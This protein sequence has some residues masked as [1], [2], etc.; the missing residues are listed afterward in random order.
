MKKEEASKCTNKRRLAMKI[1]AKIFLCLGMLALFVGVMVLYLLLNISYIKDTSSEIADRQVPLLTLAGE[2]GY[3]IARQRFAEIQHV[4]TLDATEMAQAEKKL[5]KWQE[6]A[7][8]AAE[9][10]D[11]LIYKAETRECFTRL[12]RAWRDYRQVSERLLAL[13]RQ[14]RNEEARALF[15][16]ESSNAFETLSASIGELITQL[17]VNNRAITQRGDGLYVHSKNVG[18]AIVFIVT[19]I[20]F[21]L[22]F[23]LFTLYRLRKSELLVSIAEIDEVSGLYN[24]QAFLR[25]VREIIAGNLSNNYV[26]LY[27]DIDRFRIYNDTCG[28]E[29]GNA[30]L[31]KIGDYIKRHPD[32][33][34]EDIHARFDADHFVACFSAENFDEKDLLASISQMFRDISPD[35]LCIPRLGAYQ[36]DDVSLDVGLMCDRALLAL[37]ST[38]G[39]MTRRF[40]WYD[41]A[42][43]KTTLEE[44]R[45]LSEIIAA[46][47]N[48]EFGIYLQ[49]QYDQQTRE[50]T[51]GEALARWFHPT[52][53]VVPPGVFIDTLEKNGQISDLSRQIWE[54]AA[55]LLSRRKASGKKLV[56]I[57]VN[58]SRRDLYHLNLVDELCELS[59][60]HDIEPE[61]LHLEITET[62]Y[63]ENPAQLVAV[64][65]QLRDKGFYV[66]MDDFGSGYSSLNTLKTVPVDVLK[67]DLKFL[68][69]PVDGSGNGGIILSSVIRMAHWLNLRVIA[70][71]V[72]TEQQAE[73]LQTVGCRYAQGYFYARPM[74]VSEFESLLDGGEACSHA[75]TS[76]AETYFNGSAF[77]DPE[78]QASA[79]FN[80]LVGASAILEYSSGKLSCVRANDKYIQAVGVERGMLSAFK[81]GMLEEIVEE[82]RQRV[83]DACEAAAHSMDEV[84]FEARWRSRKKP[85]EIYWL[86]IRMRRIAQSVGSTVFYSSVENITVRKNME[87]R[88]RDLLQE[89]QQ[90]NEFNRQ[91]MLRTN[92]YMFNMDLLNDILTYQYVSGEGELK[93]EIIVDYMKNYTTKLT[94]H[95]DSIGVV[96]KLFHSQSDLPQSG[97]FECRTKWLDE[98]EYTWKRVYFKAVTDDRGKTINIIGSFE[99]IENEKVKKQQIEEL[100]KQ[101]GSLTAYNSDVVGRVFQY[102]YQNTNSDT[103][104]QNV[105][106]SIGEYLGVSRVYIFENSKDNQTCSNTYEWCA[107]GI[108]PQI[109]AL[110]NFPYASVGGWEAYFRRFDRHGTF[111]VESVSALDKDLRTALEVQG[112]RSMLQCA[113]REG[114]DVIGYLGIDECSAERDWSGDV[115]GTLSMASGIIGVFLAKKKAHDK[116]V[117]AADFMDA[118]ENSGSYIYITDPVTYKILYSNKKIQEYLNHAH[119]GEPC[120]K[121]FLNYDQ[122]CAVC[123]MRIFEQSGA[124]HPVEI[125]RPNGMWVLCQASPIFWEGRKRM[126]LTCTDITTLKLAVER[127]RID[128]DALRLSMEQ[129]GKIVCLYDVAARTL[130]MPKS[131][132]A[133]RGLPESL[134]DMPHA[135]IKHWGMDRDSRN[136]R[137]YIAFYDAIHRG[138]KKGRMEIAFPTPGGGEQYFQAEFAT[139]FDDAG[140]PKQAVLALEDVT[141]LHEERNA[142]L[143]VQRQLMAAVQSAYPL[144]LAVNLTENAYS[145]INIGD[146]YPV[147]NF[148][149]EGA[150]DALANLCLNVLAPE[151][152]GAFMDMFSLENMRSAHQ[153]GKGDFRAEFRQRSDSGIWRWIE[154]LVRFVEDDAAVLC[155]LLARSIDEQ[156]ALE[157]QLQLEI[158]QASGEL[159]KERFNLRILDDHLLVQIVIFRQDNQEILYLGG[160]LF[161]SYGYTEEDIRAIREE[162][163]K[164]LYK[165]DM[166]QVV[167]TFASACGEKRPYFEI[168][169]RMMKKDGSTA[170]VMAKSSLTRNVEGV[171]VYLGII[172]DI[173]RRK[174]TERQLYAEEQFIR[175]ASGLSDRIIYRYEADAD[176]LVGISPEAC[177][178]NGLPVEWLFEA[179]A[180][181]NERIMPESREEFH[182][183]TAAIRNDGQ[184]AHARLHI[185]IG[186]AN[187]H[188]WFDVRSAS[189]QGGHDGLRSVAVSFLDIDD[190]YVKELAY[191]RYLLSVQENALNMLLYLELNL[192][193]NLVEWQRASHLFKEVELTGW[194]SEHALEFLLE[195]YFF[196]ENREEVRSTFTRKKLLKIVGAGRTTVSKEF[197][198]HF[199]DRK[200]H[201]VHIKVELVTDPYAGAGNIKAFLLVTDIDEERKKRADLLNRAERDG[202]TLLYNRETLEKRS[203]AILAAGRRCALL[204]LDL[205]NFK[206]INDTY[207][208]SQGD[209][210]LKALAKIMLS[211][212]REKDVVGRLGGDEFV[213][214]LSDISEG[215]QLHEVLLSLLHKIS[216]IRID[217]KADM[218]L[219]CSIGGCFSGPDAATFDILYSKAD[220]ALYHVKR[221]EKGHYAFYTPEMDRDDYNSIPQLLPTLQD[222]YW[223]ENHDVKHLLEAISDIFTLIISV[224]LTC[225][226]FYMMEYKTF[227]TKHASAVGNF[228]ELIRIG[229]N[230]YHPEDKVSFVEMFK[231]EKLLDAF[232]SGKKSV[233]HVGRQLGDD[234]VY[235]MICTR[236]IFFTNGKGDICE[237]TLAKPVDEEHLLD[238]K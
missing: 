85:E 192:T 96:E 143:L 228:D 159:E 175:L 201:W 21:L 237:I 103:I 70:E 140:Q 126:M 25:K 133:M 144:A 211:H 16:G 73:Y 79:I 176:R 60:R 184:P 17:E 125:L 188:R 81:D 118:I 88:Q 229:S 34:R 123:P 209:N 52:R 117:F 227:T 45:L 200:M 63:T 150:Y 198:L 55:A 173:T 221:T 189:L 74:P 66:E 44:Q 29:D 205:D 104:I 65:N 183:F 174:E 58:V 3:N 75:H 164:V 57:S 7:R 224:N 53:G 112:I 132:A 190:A 64:V 38:K 36:V 77:W 162:G 18:L 115:I 4:Y 222:V 32:T 215:T 116:A 191:A 71:G 194:S 196:E 89:L 48:G 76:F 236:V 195:R 149:R 219:Q 199:S 46:L 130:V 138:K 145:T 90:E 208:H 8:I 121:A 120:Y 108:E 136:A 50:V 172:F 141:G 47:G 168:E 13:S 109:D 84:Q 100:S 225:N 154:I 94:T 87:V 204:I 39:N 223:T 119:T 157:E 186:D 68:S 105:L 178:N 152:H 80:T 93:K 14:N 6:E 28:M 155:L 51:G 170:W 160:H 182:R 187:K 41:D 97:T 33:F 35:F 166:A 213:A 12:E 15:G 137:N 135:A 78:S 207:G 131:F 233:I 134:P 110:Q 30:L 232:R 202:L 91:M 1:S 128:E 61:L 158:S 98:K 86:D 5:E 179:G 69:G 231:R 26:I 165:A 95:P 238:F 101:L 43:L 163:G 24:K 42:M 59:R 10:F 153:S 151:D 106:K 156:K 56:P 124:G 2:F 49:P 214:L 114:N 235:R 206:K 161:K 212:F 129:M 142:F 193:A 62:V 122:P 37:R 19:V 139:I 67:L 230:T 83:L 171:D 40:A 127:Q 185:R 11:K 54:Q 23:F 113:L 217:E 226:S 72:E 102:L 22:C 111:L 177:S 27:W 220:R 218:T 148:P 180:P 9:E 92:T 203:N 147:R 146:A 197:P 82:D 181:A 210:A 31:K 20:V 169:Y 107:A 234:G 99:N 216:S 167:S